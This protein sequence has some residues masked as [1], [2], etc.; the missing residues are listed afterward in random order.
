MRNSYG[1]IKQ[2]SENIWKL[3]ISLGIGYDGKQV[4][5]SRT[6]EA[7]NEKEANRQLHLFYSEYKN[8]PNSVYDNITFYEFCRLWYTRH[9]SKLSP[10]TVVRYK[11]ILEQRILPS[12]GN[13]QLKKITAITIMSF[14]DHLKNENERLDGKD[15]FLSSRSIEIIYKLIQSIFN[16]AVEW[17][18][19]IANPCG[20]IPREEIPKAHSIRRSIWTI[21]EVN[22]FFS[23]LYRLPDNFTNVKYKLM[24]TIAWTTGARR[25]EYLGLQ[26]N[27]IDFNNQTFHINKSLTDLPGQ[28]L[29]TKAPKTEN[30]NRIVAFDSYS[31]YLFLLHKGIQDEF[32]LNT[33]LT[34]PQ[35]F[36]FISHTKFSTE[37][38]AVYP[39]TPDAFYNWFQRYIEGIGLPHIT[40]HAF[41][42]MACTYALT[43]GAPINVVQ[44][45]LGHSNIKTTEGYIHRIETPDN[46]FTNSLSSMLDD[47]RPKVNF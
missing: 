35:N 23:N 8:L 2:I 17:H 45:M 43:A 9:C 4:K 7:K 24:S 38:N 27:D 5:K 29:F 33:G 28:E 13:L 20:D 18:F 21:E 26:W 47:T 6:I 41:R 14:L 22:F 40:I 12:F 36:V 19:L 11:K 46:A 10:T 15:G 1:S 39:M 34:N 25:G 44:N 3:T 30:S 16:K 31:K 42:H 32:L 37:N